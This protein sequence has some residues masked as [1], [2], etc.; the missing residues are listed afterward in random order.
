MAQVVSTVIGSGTNG[1][2]GIVNRI[3]PSNQDSDPISF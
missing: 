1:S 3:K 2:A